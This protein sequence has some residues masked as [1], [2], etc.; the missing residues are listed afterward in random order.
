MGAGLGVLMYAQVIPWPGAMTAG[1]LQFFFQYANGAGILFAALYLISA[2]SDDRLIRGGSPLLVMALGLTA[3]VGATLCFLAGLVVLSVACRREG[4]SPWMVRTGAEVLLGGCAALGSLAVATAGAFPLGPLVS[5]AL[6]AAAVGA[7]VALEGTLDRIA[8]EV[9]QRREAKVALT[10]LAVGLAAL[11]L[12]LGFPRLIQATE[13]F[14]ERL[15]QIGDAL[16][17]WTASPLLGVGPDAW[18]HLYQQVQSVDYETTLVHGSF[19]Q[20]L[21]DGG[22]LALVPFCT[23]CFLGL[24]ALARTGQW[25]VFAAS[26]ALLLHATFDFDFRFGALLFLLLLLL[27][28]GFVNAKRIP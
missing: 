8:V 22:L 15:F 5:C 10:A 23:A 28:Y 9:I 24:R 18:Q 13:T 20:L 1:R 17:L 26:A 14:A 21:L 7:R 11:V 27:G 3:S 6:A 16:T 19:A 12:A 4:G 2:V 25:A